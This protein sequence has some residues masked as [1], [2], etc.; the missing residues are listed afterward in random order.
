M[1]LDINRELTSKL[2]VTCDMITSHLAGRKIIHS[3]T[4]EYTQSDNPSDAVL[5]YNK[6]KHRYVSV[7][8]LRQHLSKV[9]LQNY[10][11][12]RPETIHD[13]NYAVLDFDDIVSQLNKGKVRLAKAICVNVECVESYVEGSSPQYRYFVTVPSNEMSRHLPTFGKFVEYKVHRNSIVQSP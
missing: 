2:D 12:Y 4:D 5:A 7:S 11:F 6:I 8:H 1:E 10:V 3:W 9:N 13:C